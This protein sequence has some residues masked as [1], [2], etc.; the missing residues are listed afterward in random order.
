MAR[1]R[2]RVTWARTSHKINERVEDTNEGESQ[3]RGDE[4]E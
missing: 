3:W 2:K 4:R 1:G